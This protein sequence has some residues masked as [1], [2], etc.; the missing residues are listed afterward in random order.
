M[1]I[2]LFLGAPSSTSNFLIA[3]IWRAPET[4]GGNFQEERKGITIIAFFLFN[5]FF[6][7]LS[8]YNFNRK[9]RALCVMGLAIFYL[10]YLFFKIV[11]ILMTLLCGFKIDTKN[12]EKVKNTLTTSEKELYKSK[13]P[14]AQSSDNLKSKNEDENEKENEEQ[15]DK[16]NNDEE[17]KNEKN[18]EEEKDEENKKDEQNESRKE[19]DEVENNE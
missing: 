16:S 5:L 13:N 12:D 11:A 6:G 18:E 7:F 8:F 10:I 17:N 4:S 19:D 3:K 9:K 2:Y 14:L 15:L 1:F